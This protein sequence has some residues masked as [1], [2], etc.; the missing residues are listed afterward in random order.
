MFLFQYHNRFVRSFVRSV[1]SFVLSCT[2]M[3]FPC[4]ELNTDLYKNIFLCSLSFYLFPRHCKLF[5]NFL[6]CL[7]YFFRRSLC[8]V[9]VCVSFSLLVLQEPHCWRRCLKLYMLQPVV[10][11]ALFSQVGLRWGWCNRRKKH[12]FRHKT[13]ASSLPNLALCFLESLY[14]RDSKA[15]FDSRLINFT[16]STLWLII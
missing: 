6:F 16:L 11:S 15:V 2:P 4:T 1:W 9:S 8:Y 13:F 7:V 10:R 3:H 14:M 12:Y 5:L